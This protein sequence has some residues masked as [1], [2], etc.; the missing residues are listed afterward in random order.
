M[1]AAG[2]GRQRGKCLRF[3]EPRSSRLAQVTNLVWRR[4]EKKRRGKWERK[5]GKKRRKGR[6]R[7]EAKGTGEEE[8]D[9]EAEGEQQIFAYGC[10]TLHLIVSCHQARTASPPHF[11]GL[12]SLSV[13]GWKHTAYLDSSFFSP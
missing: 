1:P 4:R 3:A 8:K 11:L 10:L 13:L 7:E 6:R 5:K 12:L 9:G 2:T